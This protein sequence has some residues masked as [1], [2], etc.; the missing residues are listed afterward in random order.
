MLFYQL[1]FDLDTHSMSKYPRSWR[2]FSASERSFRT[3]STLP[4]IVTT[5]GTT[6]RRTEVFFPVI[7]DKI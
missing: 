4:G 5:F 1:L 7:I 2:D 3:E 6:D